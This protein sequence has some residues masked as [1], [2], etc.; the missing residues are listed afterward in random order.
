M[1]LPMTQT[2]TTQLMYKS[3]DVLRLPQIWTLLCLAAFVGGLTTTARCEDTVKVDVCKLRKIP[4]P[5]ITNWSKSRVS[6]HMALKILRYPT[7][8]AY[9]ALEFGWNM[10]ER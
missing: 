3:L 4:R 8:G 1:R 6:C 7:R 10:V 5:T 9:P 2:L